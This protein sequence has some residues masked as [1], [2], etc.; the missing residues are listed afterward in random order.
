[1]FTRKFIMYFAR[2]FKKIKGPG[3]GFIIS[4]AIFV[5]LNGFPR[6]ASYFEALC[7]WQDIR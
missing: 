3:L 1:M 6:R 5:I 7:M 4:R 2:L